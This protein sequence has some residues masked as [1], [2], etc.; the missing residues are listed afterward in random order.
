[1]KSGDG[2]QVL[3]A[4]GTIALAAAMSAGLILAA[5]AAARALCL[6]APQCAFLAS[7]CQLRKAAA[8]R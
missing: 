2:W 7:S 1:M 8:S 6:G 3:I 4:L 5:A